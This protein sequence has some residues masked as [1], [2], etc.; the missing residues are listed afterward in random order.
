[1]SNRTVILC[2]DTYGKPFLRDLTNRLKDHN[3]VSQALGVDTDK[4]YGACNVKLE[5]QLKAKSRNRVRRFII[6]V[7]S[8]GKN[9]IFLAERVQKHIPQHLQTITNIIV[10]DYEI[11]DWLCAGLGIR[12]NR[13]SSEIMKEQYGYEK[14]D[15][16]SYVPRLDIE[17]LKRCTS[18]RDFLTSL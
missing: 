4:F 3:L 16:V 12:I 9:K 11:E 1:M 15:L 7:D 6:L 8:D 2:E 10:F 13:R 18:F 5:R 17:G 14:H